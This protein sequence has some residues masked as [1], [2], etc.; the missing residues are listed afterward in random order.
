MGNDGGVE[1]LFGT[2]VKEILLNPR[3]SSL[4]FISP[5]AM[6][7]QLQSHI[8]ALSLHRAFVEVQPPISSSWYSRMKPYKRVC[9]G[10]KTSNKKFACKFLHFLDD[11]FSSRSSTSHLGRSLPLCS[12]TSMLFEVLGCLSG[13]T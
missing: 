11:I 1:C 4:N 8:F 12:R 9:R 10:K 2:S 7:H 3:F 13:H 6:F 5:D